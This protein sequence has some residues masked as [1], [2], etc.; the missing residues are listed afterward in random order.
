ML[1]SDNSKPVEPILGGATVDPWAAHVH[2]EPGFED[3]FCGY[4]A[5]N[6]FCYTFG[7]AHEIVYTPA[8][9]DMFA[10]AFAISS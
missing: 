10:D 6:G 1:P 8:H 4:E 5:V 9:S 3:G 7:G 2:D